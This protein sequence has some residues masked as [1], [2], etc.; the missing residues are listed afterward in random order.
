MNKTIPIAYQVTIPISPGEMIPII[1]N[2]VPE[3]V[4][5]HIWIRK[6]EKR[7]IKSGYKTSIATVHKSGQRYEVLEQYGKVNE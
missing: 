4:S 7:W 1:N 5:G 6:E 3:V 2:G